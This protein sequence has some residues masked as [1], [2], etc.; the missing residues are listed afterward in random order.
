MNLLISFFNCGNVYPRINNNRADFIV[1]NFNN[2]FEIVI[3]HFNNYPLCN[4]KTL[5]FNDFTKAA[6]LFKE[7]GQN[8]SEKIAKIVSNINSRRIGKSG[9][10]GEGD[11]DK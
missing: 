4:I 10:A 3:P 7:G 8:N 9:S 11:R 1:Q 2:I 6:L 5:D